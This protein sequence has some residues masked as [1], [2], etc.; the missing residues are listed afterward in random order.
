MIRHIDNLSNHTFLSKLHISENL[1]LC[2]TCVNTGIGQAALIAQIQ[3]VL[4][5][6]LC[7]TA[8]L[9]L[10]SSNSQWIIVVPDQ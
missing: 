10:G 1:S 4:R 9:G 3:I 7:F 6:K 2:L 5:F 8:G